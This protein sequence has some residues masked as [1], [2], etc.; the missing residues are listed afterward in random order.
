MAQLGSSHF[1]WAMLSQTELSQAVASLLKSHCPNLEIPLEPQHVVC[2]TLSMTCS[3]LL[4]NFVNTP[5]FQGKETWSMLTSSSR[6]HLSNLVGIEPVGGKKFKVSKWAVQHSSPSQ[7][8]VFHQ[9]LQTPCCNCQI[10][11]YMLRISG[12][13]FDSTIKVQS[14]YSYVP[15]H[16]LAHSASVDEMCTCRTYPWTNNTCQAKI[17]KALMMTTSLWQ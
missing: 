1:G 13:R 11:I 12:P 9:P 3:H 10:Y 6:H 15:A 14:K 4:A 5:R 7:K 17:K 8:I 2:M 16:P